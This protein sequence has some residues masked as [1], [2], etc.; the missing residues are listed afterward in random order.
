[1]AEHGDFDL[2]LMDVQ[3]PRLTGLEAA[4]AIRGLPGRADTPIVALTAS[5]FDQDRRACVTAGM[6]DFIAKP[7]E[8]DQVFATVLKWLEPP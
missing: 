8:P 3:M 5:T 7:L 4:R 6:N 2:I 1:M